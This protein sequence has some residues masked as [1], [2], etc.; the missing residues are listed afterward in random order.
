VWIAVPV[1]LIVVDQPDHESDAVDDT[2][3]EEQ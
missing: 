2:K 1:F 3:S